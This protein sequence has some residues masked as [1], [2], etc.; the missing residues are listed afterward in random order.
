MDFF[1][2]ADII[3]S[4]VI[5]MKKEKPITF[6]F[7]DR[8]FIQSNEFLHSNLT[9]YK[10]NR[11]VR[12]G[13][14]AKING[15]TYENLAYK[16]SE[17]DF[18]YVSGYINEGVVCLMSAAAFHGLSTFRT[19]QVD[20]A[21]R[22]KSKIGVLPQWPAIGVFYF[23]KTRYET[24]V[25]T[26]EIEGGSFMVFDREKTVCDLLA[27]RNKYGLEDCLSV[28]KSYL[29]REDRD[30]SKLISYAEKLRCYNVL[31]KYLEVLI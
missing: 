5:Q 26:V 27:Y 9:Y 21:V 17:S 6:P 20:V 22:Q 15:N 18:L 1:L 14:V 29:R 4:R 8:K 13:A 11:L 2:F 7:P 16:G 30:I 28:L 24:G 10:I 25:Q 23:S 3:Y 12:E 19:N 31:S